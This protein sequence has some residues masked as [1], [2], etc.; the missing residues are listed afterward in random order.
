MDMTLA[1]DLY[2]SNFMSQ[3]SI[4]NG[5]INEHTNYDTNTVQ[6]FYFAKEG[7]F[8][9]KFKQ[10]T[11]KIETADSILASLEHDGTE[12]GKA[13]AIAK[14]MVSNVEYDDDYNLCHDAYGALVAHKA[15]CDGYA[16]AYDLLC[17]R[18]ELE[19]IYITGATTN[20]R[21]T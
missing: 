6:S 18:A 15:V 10:Y 1:R 5:Y 19:T 2:I 11:D 20:A 7:D 16:S 4:V 14:W 13:L 9:I 12:Y 21:H 3:M 8:D 17:K